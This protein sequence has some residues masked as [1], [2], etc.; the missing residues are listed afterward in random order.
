LAW[1]Q[2]NT[3]FGTMPVCRAVAWGWLGDIALT[4]EKAPIF[5]FVG[6]VLL[7]VFD[8]LEH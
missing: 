1:Q 8:Q 2:Y 7:S 6:P 3:W 5:R 4:E